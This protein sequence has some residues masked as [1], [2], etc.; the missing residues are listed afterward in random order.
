MAALLYTYQPTYYYIIV[1]KK[2]AAKP[3]HSQRF[4]PIRPPLF[5]ISKWQSR[6]LSQHFTMATKKRI[7][8]KNVQYSNKNGSFFLKR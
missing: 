2:K 3:L 1:A 7:S 6:V 8:F 4:Y 5:W